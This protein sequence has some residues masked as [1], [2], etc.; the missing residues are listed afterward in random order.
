[1]ATTLHPLLGVALA[2]EFLRGQ[3]VVVLE[4]VVLGLVLPQKALVFDQFRAAFLLL[5][6][7]P[8][9]QPCASD[10]LPQSLKGNHRDDGWSDDGDLDAV[11][12][13]WL[14]LLLS[15]IA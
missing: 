5:A 8:S 14:T 9:L 3:L 13:D 2:A 4:V 7:F 12:R 10:R 6:A 15:L 11:F 1:M